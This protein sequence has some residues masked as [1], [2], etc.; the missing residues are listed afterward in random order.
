MT[1]NIKLENPGT[2]IQVYLDA[3][4]AEVWLTSDVS[5]RLELRNWKTLVF[6]PFPGTDNF[7]PNGSVLNLANS[8]G[9]TD[10]VTP[11]T[12]DHNPLAPYSLYRELKWSIDDLTPFSS[13]R[14]KLIGTTTNQHIP[15]TLKTL[16][17]LV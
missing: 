16:E 3:Y 7:Q 11:K 12:D 14:I 10:V 2:S 15:H 17:R 8:N 6:I 13:F 1:K 9:S 5:I 4:L